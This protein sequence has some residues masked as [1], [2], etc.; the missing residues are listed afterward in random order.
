M[1]FYFK[2]IGEIEKRAEE[3]YQSTKME[4]NKLHGEFLRL[5]SDLRKNPP[6]KLDPSDDRKVRLFDL[7]EQVNE[8]SLKVNWLD[9]LRKRAQEAENKDKLVELTL[10]EMVMLFPEG[11]AEKAEAEKAE[12]E[13]KDDKKKK[14]K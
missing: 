9:S 11:N 12:T 13:T 8:L 6:K 10:N 3:L 14:K 7:G 4:Y 2:T 1:D 5:Q